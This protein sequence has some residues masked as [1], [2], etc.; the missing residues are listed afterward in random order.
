[1]WVLA[2]LFRPVAA[3]ILFGLVC[4]PIRMAVNRFIPDGRLKTILLTPI[5]RKKPARTYRAA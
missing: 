2:L 4:L 3:L 1:M 5:G